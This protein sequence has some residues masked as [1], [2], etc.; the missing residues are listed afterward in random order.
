[1][2]VCAKRAEQE[3]GWTARTEFADGV[4]RYVDWHRAEYEEPQEPA[5]AREV[6]ERGPWRVLAGLPLR[7]A[8][9]V[10]LLAMAVFFLAG[11]DS[12][13]FYAKDVRTLAITS[14][15]GLT[16]FLALSSDPDAQP[17]N[18]G[19]ARIGWLLTGAL[20]AVALVGPYNPHHL[21]GPDLELLALSFVGAGL[22]VSTGAVGRRALRERLRERASDASS[23]AS[24]ASR[25]EARA[26]RSGPR[27]PA[28]PRPSPASSPARCSVGVVQEDHVA[29]AQLRA[30]VGGDRVRGRAAAPVAPPGDQSHGSSPRRRTSARPAG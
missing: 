9:G 16:L 25:D 13:G 10:G 30:R 17:S 29:P 4:A 20:L 11:I 5:V 21:A 26:R 27:S 22:G 19:L 18:S 15:V 2:E 6:E 7:I 1:M 23:L 12:D 14:L 28:A 3:L 24:R 8:A